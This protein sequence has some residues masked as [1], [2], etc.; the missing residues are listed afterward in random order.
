MKTTMNCRSSKPFYFTI[1]LLLV[2]ISMAVMWGCE[3]K[4]PVK[5]GFVGGLTGRLSYLGTAGR[6]GVILAVEEINEAGGIN[7]R[8]VELITRDDGHDPKVAVKVDRELIGEGV[9]AIIGHMTSSMSMAALPLIN[10]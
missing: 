4:K 5:V 9:V 7:G 10:K 6:N 2:S 3:N 8:P 1:I